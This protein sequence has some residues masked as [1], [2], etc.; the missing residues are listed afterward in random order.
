MSRPFRIVICS[1]FAL[2]TPLLLCTL[3]VF[4][5]RGTSFGNTALDVGFLIVT[6]CAGLFFVV[7]IPVSRWARVAIGVVALP[8]SLVLAAAWGFWLACAEFRSCL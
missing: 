4:L 6:T 3:G 8:I 1:V 2:F 7:F 5:T